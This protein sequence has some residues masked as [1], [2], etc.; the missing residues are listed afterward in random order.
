MSETNFKFFIQFIF[1]TFLLCT[2]TIVI[3]AYYIGQQSTHGVSK[4]EPCPVHHD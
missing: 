4:L 3:L 2:F 1:Y